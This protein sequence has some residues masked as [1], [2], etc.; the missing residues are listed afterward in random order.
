MRSAACLFS[1][2]FSASQMLTTASPSRVKMEAL[3]LTRLIH[4]SAFACRATEETRVRKVRCRVLHTERWI[5]D[6]ML[7]EGIIIHYV[8]EVGSNIKFSTLF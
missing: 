3:A 4:I 2:L 8:I 1:L 7:C 6:K 5:K